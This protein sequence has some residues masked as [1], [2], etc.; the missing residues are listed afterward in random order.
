MG[1]SSV[2]FKPDGKLSVCLHK[3]YINTGDFH[4]SDVISRDYLSNYAWLVD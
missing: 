2:T 1:Y 3:T 4:N